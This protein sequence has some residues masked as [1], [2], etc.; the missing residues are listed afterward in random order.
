MR[1]RIDVEANDILELFGEFEI[2][3]ELEW[4]HPMPLKPCL[5]Q[6]RRTEEGLI[7]TALAIADA[8][9]WVASCGGAWL[10]GAT[11]RSTVSGGKAGMR[12]GRVLSRVNPSTP[13]RMKRSCQRQTTVLPLP[14]ARITAV[15]P[16]LSAVRTMIRARPTCFCGLFRS[17]MIDC[18]RIRS[19][20]VTVMEIPLRITDHRTKPNVQ[21][22]NR[23]NWRMDARALPTVGRS[24]SPS[25]RRMACGLRRPSEMTTG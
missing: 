6:M 11:T 5:F 15:V 3:G 4:A 10:V 25:W 14:T 13:S 21:K 12:E 8:V 20:G 18:K 2:V 22:P 16:S 9:Q 17:R 24:P 1:R 23:S 7:P 19:A